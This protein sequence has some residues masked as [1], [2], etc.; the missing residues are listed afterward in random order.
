LRRSIATV[1]AGKFSPQKQRGRPGAIKSRIF[2][3]KSSIIRAN[4][5]DFRFEPLDFFSIAKNKFRKS[6]DFQLNIAVFDALRPRRRDNFDVKIL[7]GAKVSN[8]A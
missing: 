4:F 2:L 8:R 7:L 6:N 1:Q 3:K 5:G